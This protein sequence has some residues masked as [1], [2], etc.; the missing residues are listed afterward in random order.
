MG[1]L[2][3]RANRVV[4]SLLVLMAFGPLVYGDSRTD[5]VDALFSKWD[6]LDSPGCALGII[7]DAEFVHKRGYGMA[8]LE[9]SIPISSAS[10]FR[11]GS[12]SKQFTTISVLL[13]AQ[14]GKLSL[15]DDIRKYVPE[16]PQ[17]EKTVTIRHLIHHTSGI[18]DYLVLMFLAGKREEDYYTNEEVLENLSRLENLN[19]APGDEYLYSNSGYWLLSQIIERATGQ[20]LRQWA[21]EELF[22]P[23]GM[24]NTHFHDDPRMIVKNRASG[25]RRKEDGGF[26]L[27]MTSLEMVGDGG[28]FTTIDDLSKWDRNFDHKTLGGEAVMKELLTP[29][30]LN[31]GK[32]QDYAGGLGVSRYRGLNIVEHGGSFVGFRAGMIRFP[33]HKF[34]A[35]CLCNLSEINPMELLRKTADTYLKEQFEDE[36]VKFAKLSENTLQEKVGTYWSSRLSGLVDVKMEEGNLAL[37][38]LGAPPYRLLPLNEEQFLAEQ[39]LTRAE[40]RFVDSG[41]ATEGMQIQFEGQR[42]FDFELVT[43]VSPSSQDLKAYEGDYFCRELDATYRVRLGDEKKLVVEVAHLPLQTLEP[44]FQDGFRYEFGNIVFERSR[45]GNASGFRLSAY[46]ARN[47]EFKRK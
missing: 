14:K 45:E 1:K 46:R 26:E 16:M 19:F 30:V 11:T 7:E 44:V 25:Y 21:K 4:I 5:Q 47:F 37:H 6:R 12:V 40:V 23:L 17:Q 38:F 13:A 3:F 10:V 34:S 35:Y 9:H 43:P 31:S 24:E 22:S 29:G 32:T 28:V 42:R 39:G 2:R 27:D 36:D 41:G 8:N 33:D 15:D 18:R 20:S